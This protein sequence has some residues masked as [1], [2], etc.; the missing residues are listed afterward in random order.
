MNGNNLT[1]ASHTELLAAELLIDTIKSVEMVKFAKN[2]S[3][4]TTA[5]IKVARA[6]TSRKYIAVPRQHPFFSFDDWFISSTSVKRGIP[7]EN[8]LLTLTFDFNNIKSLEKLF[9]DYR[10]QIAAVI[11]EPST[12][13]TPCQGNS[14]KLKFDS[15]C[16]DC[17]DYSDNFLFLVRQLCSKEGSL[18]IFDEMITG[19]RFDLGG[20]QNKFSV[21]P[22]LCC[23]GKAMAN[24]FSLAA[25]GGKREFMSVGSIDVPGSERT[26][27]LSSTHGAE[28][29]SLGAFIKTVQIY[30]EQSVCKALWDYGYKLSSEM[31][32]LVQSKGLSEYF[33]ITG[34]D[35]LLSYE[36]LNSN[37][38]NDLYFRSL[39]LQEMVSNKVLMPWISTSTSHN[40]LELEITLSAF[41][42]A[43][44]I[45][46][47]ALDSGIEKFLSGG[48]IKPVFRKIN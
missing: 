36:T 31:K 21:E 33:K 17:P 19:F 7:N 13:L 10:D 18:L 9:E 40:D 37:K 24:G 11:L 15:K 12:H 44:D 14:C 43:L 20:A 46:T 23:F 34:P 28:M 2:G 32:S 30:K 4:I 26:F 39:F 42:H 48:P 35:I 41:D 45:Y 6:Y 1:R 27:L 8:G 38:Q 25:L 47:K 3:N 16:M 29:T 22:D 5:A